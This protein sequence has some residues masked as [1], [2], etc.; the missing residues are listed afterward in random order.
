MKTELEYQI[1]SSKRSVEQFISIRWD[2]PF[3]LKTTLIEYE[4]KS[5]N[6]N[7]TSQSI[8]DLSALNHESITFK[9]DRL[10]EDYKAVVS[11]AF[12]QK[13]LEQ[14]FSFGNRIVKIVWKLEKMRHKQIAF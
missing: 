1:L 14:N 2:T 4:R 5:I 6:I 11:D 8:T 12:N 3:N 7:H 10:I 9:S 13:S